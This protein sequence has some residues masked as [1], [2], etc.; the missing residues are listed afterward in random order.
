MIRLLR[1]EITEQVTTFDGVRDDSLA[2][3]V[4]WRGRCI[5]LRSLRF[6]ATTVERNGKVFV[7]IVGF[8]DWRLRRASL[9]HRFADIVKDIENM[10]QPVTTH[11][12]SSTQ[13]AI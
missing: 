6:A 5:V 2:D 8:E 1:Q 3:G 13:R 7:N 11:G 4:Q 9:L 12:G 10:N